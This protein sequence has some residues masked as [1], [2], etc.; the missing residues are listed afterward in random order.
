MLTLA[1]ISCLFVIV[2]LKTEDERLKIKKRKKVSELLEQLNST[3]CMFFMLNSKNN[4][5]ILKLT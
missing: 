2:R 5:L 3:Q 1:L 4:P